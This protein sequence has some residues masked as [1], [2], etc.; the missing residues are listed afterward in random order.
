M[1]GSKG[2]VDFVSW[3]SYGRSPEEVASHIRELRTILSKYPQ[4]TPELFI[5]EFNVLQGG[6]GDTSANGNTDRV[7]GA[8]AFLASI[9]SMQR[10]RLDRAFLFELKDGAGYRPF[11]GRWGILTNDG[12]AKPIYHALKAFL[13][14]PAGA[15][16]VTVRRTPGDGTPGLMAFGTPQRATLLLWYTGTDGARIKLQMPNGFADTDFDLT[17]FDADHN[18][19]AKSG[20]S[21]VKRWLQR[22]AGD[23]V[24][25]LKQNSLVILTS[26]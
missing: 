8:I 16:P 9:E 12:Q 10:E 26:R 1:L 18:N 11:W 25:E 20:D 23:L 24:L 3:H 17:L 15:L 6:P 5:T 19:P 13:N 14:R 2:R 22:N 7:E 4:F 21:T